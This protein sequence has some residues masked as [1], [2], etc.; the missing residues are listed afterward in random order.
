MATL[1]GMSLLSWLARQSETQQQTHRRP[2]SRIELD[3][4]I[5][6]VRLVAGQA[7][8]VGVERR[9]TWSGPK[10]VLEE[11]WSGET[12]RVEATCD[13]DS[14]I[15]A[16]WVGYR[17]TVPPGV[18]VDARTSEGDITLRDLTGVL[19]LA[20]ATGTIT[21]TGLRTADVGAGTR[22]GD[23]VL[24]FV[25]APGSLR[26]NSEAGDIDLEVPESDGYALDIRGGVGEQNIGVRATA[27]AANI[28]SVRNT[29]GGVRVAYLGS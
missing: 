22:M 16:C 28:I 11:R 4:G 3:L 29:A 24:R 26:T 6:E 19:R 5:G 21:G 14:L 27:D 23:I 12:F 8:Q 10:P 7:G 20:T 15:A 25:R 17:L 9:M 18:T 1:S 13:Q 2:V